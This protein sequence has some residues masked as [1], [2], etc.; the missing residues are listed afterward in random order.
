MELFNDI[1]RTE[2]RT[3]LASDTKH[4]YL[5]ISARPAAQAVRELLTDLVDRYPAAHRND[6]VRRLRSIDRQHESAVFELLVHEMLIRS[7]CEIVAVEPVLENRGTTPDFLVRAADG[8]RFFVECVV[9]NGVSDAEAGRE[10]LLISA[11]DRVR[12][13]PSPAH[14]LAVHVRGAPSAAL[15][16]KALS[17]GLARWVAGLPEGEAA[18]SAAPFMFERNGLKLRIVVM[19]PRMLPAPA[20]AISVGAISFGLRAST[21]GDDLRTSL[22]KKA[23]KYRD[24]GLPYVIAVNDAG[25]SGAAQ[26]MDALLGSPL[27]V[28][29]EDDDGGSDLPTARASDGLWTDQVRPRKRGVSAVLWLH[30]A[31]SWKPWGRDIVLVRNPWATHALPQGTLPFPA[32]NPQGAEFVSVAGVSG[33]ELFG[34]AED[35]PAE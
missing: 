31:Y 26:L 14:V 35:W 15:D 22:M 11:L 7:G 4:G 2:L 21:P 9:A 23:K 3:P 33:P 18:M 25:R 5:N 27:A 10:R 32:L 1:A 28:F 13:T 8:S 17:R 12:S 19:A 6:L 24:L 30:G 16:L 29:R 20:G 34:L